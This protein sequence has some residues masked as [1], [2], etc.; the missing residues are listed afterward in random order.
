MPIQVQENL[1]V[2]ENRAAPQANPALP[3]IPIP[4][5]LRDSYA[6]LNEH[7]RG[8]DLSAIP[9]IVGP[10]Q[11]ELAPLPVIQQRRILAQ[12][13]NNAQ[14]DFRANPLTSVE[15]LDKLLRSSGQVG[16]AKVTHSLLRELREL[17]KQIETTD[18]STLSDKDNLAAVK[19]QFNERKQHID[20][21][22]R[23]L[24]TVHGFFLDRG[25]NN[26]LYT[27]VPV[28]G[29]IRAST[30]KADLQTC[31]LGVGQARNGNSF[32]GQAFSSGFAVIDSSKLSEEFSL[33]RVLANE[34][35]HVHLN[36][37][38]G[39]TGD[40]AL[41]ENLPVPA[42][43]EHF[44]NSPKA[45]AEL[46]TQNAKPQSLAEI[47][48]LISDTWST[49]VELADIDRILEYGI[50]YELDPSLRLASKYSSQY[51][52]SSQLTFSAVLASHIRDGKGGEFAAK[53]GELQD[54]MKRLDELSDKLPTLDDR[55]S[56]E[57][58][59]KQI[60]EISDDFASKVKQVTRDIPDQYRQEAREVLQYYADSYLEQLRR[61][62]VR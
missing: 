55:E 23:T 56:R 20:Q 62:K 34:L 41:P 37:N 50:T 18:P 10:P 46:V 11:V 16:A 31:V 14:R 51:R 29:L 5:E 9:E 36:F 48:E 54:F 38:E 49:K 4:K 6:V 8:L 21:M 30:K 57:N 22:I 43:P 24:A 40:S 47:H 28:D 26:H 7:L 19:Q 13:A 25:S 53:I 15:E 17:L 33:S 59:R 27:V 52:L 58:A 42:L 2:Q 45:L 61:A 35:A 3:Q 39:I 12:N 44:S 1:Q 32:Q 60:K